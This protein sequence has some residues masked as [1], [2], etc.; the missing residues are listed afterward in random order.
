[1]RALIV[2]NVPRVSGITLG[3]VVVVVVLIVI[4][5]VL[6]A[7]SCIGSFET[8]M[9]VCDRLLRALTTFKWSDLIL[10]ERSG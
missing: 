7:F 4:N 2:I 9:L 6:L 5:V 3:G 1:M 8:H 10:I